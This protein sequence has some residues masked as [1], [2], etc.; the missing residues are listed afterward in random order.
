MGMKP[1]VKH[2]TTEQNHV[3]IRARRDGW[4]YGVYARAQRARLM[5]G[6]SDW[7]DGF[8]RRWGITGVTEFG[9]A[10]LPCNPCRSL[11][12]HAARALCRVDPPPPAP[13]PHLPC[14]GPGVW[15]ASRQQRVGGAHGAQ[16]RQLGAQVQPA[17]LQ[18]GG[19]GGGRMRGEAVEAV[20]SVGWHASG[21]AP[22]SWA[23]DSNTT[24][25]IQ[26]NNAS[27]DVRPR[28]LPAAHAPY[29]PPMPLRLLTSGV[30]SASW[31]H[32]TSLL[33]LPLPLPPPAPAL[34]PPPPP[35]PP[36]QMASSAARSSVLKPTTP[37]SAS[38]CGSTWPSTSRPPVKA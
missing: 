21:R 26:H 22:M 6:R 33:P 31:Q 1:C 37:Y 5:A 27:R 20:D 19:G 29:R 32:T 10:G 23:L 28:P 15:P 34:A 24:S 9:A 16:H 13:A 25:G 14:P 12:G 30:M 11:Y 18:G 17:A 35:P 3:C 2:K 7:R 38:S 8:V 36:P 4:G